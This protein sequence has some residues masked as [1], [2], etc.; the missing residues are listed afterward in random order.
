MYLSNHIIDLMKIWLKGSSLRKELE[1]APSNGGP[2]SHR[3]RS[4]AQAETGA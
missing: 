4:A 2:K 1:L 3:A